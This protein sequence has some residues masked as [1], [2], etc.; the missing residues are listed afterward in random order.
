MLSFQLV[1]NPGAAF[2]LAEE[3]TWVLTII[4][5]LAV[6]AITWYAWTVQSRA[7]AVALGMLLGGAITHLGDRL[8]REPGFA[9][10]HV[11]DFIN[12][13]GY[14]IGN[15]A[16]IALVGGAVMIV[17]ISIMGISPPI[18]LPP[19]LAAPE[20]FAG[21]DDEALVSDLHVEYPHGQLHCETTSE[22]VSH[23]FHTPQGEARESS[24]WSANDTRTL[25]LWATRLASD[26]HAL[27]PNVLDDI[28]QAAAWHDAG[29][30]LYICE[31]AEPAQLDLLEIEVEGELL[32]LP[33]LG[34]GTVGHDHIEGE[35]HPI[36]LLWAR[37]RS[38]AVAASG[39]IWESTPT[40]SST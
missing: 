3:Y 33:W 8:F 26:F 22:G 24:P 31:V 32:T 20:L 19:M 10:G 11:V 34:A 1:Y 35:N 29:F 21:W 30:D 36:A 25:V 4:A 6:V 17:V 9:R 28:T 23:H 38:S 40:H 37:V 18:D 12:Y 16:D 27:L 39:F 2:S 14:F 15:I 13:N 7:W 5:A